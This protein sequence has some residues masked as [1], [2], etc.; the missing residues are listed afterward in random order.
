MAFEYPVHCTSPKC[1]QLAEYKLASRWSDGMTE[2]LKTYGLACST[3]LPEMFRQTVQRF[4]KITVMAEETLD[5]PGIFLLVKGSHD[6][7]LAR[8]SDLEKKIRSEMSLQ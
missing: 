6:R 5:P 1:N 2:E 3:C 7:T 8:Q 4:G